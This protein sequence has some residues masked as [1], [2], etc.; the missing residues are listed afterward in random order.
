MV[1]AR[2][3]VVAAAAAAGA[4][5]P[6]QRVR[7]LSRSDRDR[8]H[9]SSGDRPRLRDSHRRSS[10]LLLRRGMWRSALRGL[11]NSRLG[12]LGVVLTTGCDKTTPACL[13]GAATVNIPAIVLSGGPMLN[14]WFKGERT[15]SGTI[16]W[17]AR[18]L[19]AAGEIDDDGFLRITDRKKDLIITAGGKAARLQ[20]EAIPVQ[21]RATQGK[22]L[23][24]VKA[25]DRVV[26]V[27]R[28][29]GRS[30]RVPPTDSGG[31]GGGAPGSELVDQMELLG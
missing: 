12:M 22:Q 3:V 30:A 29:S 4:P 10:Q 11:W 8:R 27:T 13:M 28:A 21:G 9:E 31:G 6:E 7:R 18:E 20:A 2:G 23:V 24:K 16:V 5:S 19:H 26:E 17:K 25:G 15:G 14:G 1:D